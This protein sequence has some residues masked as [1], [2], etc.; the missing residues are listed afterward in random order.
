MASKWLLGQPVIENLLQGIVTNSIK[1]NA[2]FQYKSGMQPKIVRRTDGNCCEWCSRMAGEYT[3]PDCP[4]DVYRRHNNC[5]CTVEYYPGDGR[6]QVIWSKE[7]RKSPKVIEPRQNIPAKNVLEVYKRNVEE[8]RINR[9]TKQVIRKY[10]D[11]S[12]P[13]SGKFTNEKGYNKIKNA[14]EVKYAQVLYKK[15][16]GNI[17][18]LNK[19]EKKRRADYMWNNK[20]WE[21]KTASSVNSLDK[22]V[23]SG[24]GQIKDNPGGLIIQLTEY[25]SLQD[26]EETVLH[27]LNRSASDYMIKKID[28]FVF[29]DEDIIFAISW[30]KMR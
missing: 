22:Q 18:L 14:N 16:G 17:C 25:I 5:N 24:L 26:I 4:P 13:D 2:E 8:S 3:Y 29:D 28:V 15:F 21:H 10:F 12:T 1:E 30:K 23:Q 20:Y 7:Q 6:T 27:R 9:N 11:K 19:S